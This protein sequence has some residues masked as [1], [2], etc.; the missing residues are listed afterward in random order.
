MKKVN[1]VKSF[2][3]VVLAFLGKFESSLYAQ[4]AVKVVESYRYSLKDRVTID[5]GVS[6]LPLD[7]FKK[8]LQ[9]DLGVSYQF[10]D[11]FTWDVVNA[12]YTFLNFDTGLKSD[13]EDQTEVEVDEG[14]IKDLSFRVSSRGYLNLLY[15]KSNWFNR[16]IVY[17]LWQ[18]GTGATYF[19]MGKKKQ[20]G[21]DLVV[22]GR[23]FLSDHVTFNV[24]AG[25]SI[26]IRSS[27]P[28]GIMNVGLGFSYA[29]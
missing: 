2:S 11:F 17:H 5:F 13:I 12:G 19:H 7:A 20:I 24:T 14:S 22:R 10:S 3:I 28:R 26:G 8:P 15:S 29:F 9:V 27:G 21:A 16:G 23:F 18:V 25:H 6:S 1:L 4:D